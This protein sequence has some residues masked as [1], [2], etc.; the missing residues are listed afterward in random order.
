MCGTDDGMSLHHVK[1]LYWVEHRQ[2]NLS[3]LVE[4]TIIFTNVIYV[5]I[6]KT[7][8][9]ATAERLASQKTMRDIS[10][11]NQI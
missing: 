9:N 7:L 4:D 10:F 3:L 8:Q 1:L 6:P 11:V 2:T 5:Q